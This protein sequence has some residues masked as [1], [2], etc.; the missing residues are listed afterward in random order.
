MLLV[1]IFKQQFTE[2]IVC[3]LKKAENLLKKAEKFNDKKR[4]Q[5]FFKH[6]LRKN[7]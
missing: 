1:Q 7:H 3:G 4:Q 5:I 6:A 2:S